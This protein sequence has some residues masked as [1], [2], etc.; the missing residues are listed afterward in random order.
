MS[1]GLD[2]L[3]AKELRRELSTISGLDLPTTLVFDY[4]SIKSAS[5]FIASQ[6]PLPTTAVVKQLAATPD[7]QLDAVRP[8]ARQSQAPEASARKASAPMGTI[9]AP[10]DDQGKLLRNKITKMRVLS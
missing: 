8:E 5:N 1:S 2:S 6:L 3:G 10:M 4:P 7:A 9:T